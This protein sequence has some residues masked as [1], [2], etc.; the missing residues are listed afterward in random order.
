MEATA[1]TLGR[2]YEMNADQ[3]SLDHATINAREARMAFGRQQRLDQA[4]FE[5]SQ[6]RVMADQGSDHNHP[7]EATAPG[8][9]MHRNALLPALPVETPI[10][11]Q[12]LHPVTPRRA[13]R[14]DDQAQPTPARSVTYADNRS[15]NVRHIALMSDKDNVY[16]SIAQIVQLALSENENQLVESSPLTKAGVKIPPPECYTGSD[17][18]EDFEVFISSMLRWLKINGL[19]GA[20][21]RDWQLTVLGTRLEG[22][23]QEWYMQNIESPTRAIQVWTLETA[24]VGLQRRFLP[25]LTH[26][27]TTAN[28]DVVRQ[29]NSTV[30]E[31][32]NKMNKLAERMV[33]PPD[34]YTFRQRFLEALRP[35]ISTKVLELGYNAERHDL[36][37]LYTTAKQLDEA[38]L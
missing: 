23:A 5:V 25:T 11:D 18:L 28:F 4:G 26:R 7:P 2:L 33:H 13:L 17:K 10:P 32:Y 22:E 38:K 29:S 31:L 12:V 21:S 36:Q 16:D 14:F 20:A 19:L 27:H 8:E 37:Q 30:Q 6:P 34:A 15:L 35:S 1:Q 9:P 3:A 24:V